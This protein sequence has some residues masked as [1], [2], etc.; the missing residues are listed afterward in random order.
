MSSQKSGN[1]KPNITMSEIARL[2][3]VSQSTVLRV[4]SGTTPVAP[5]KQAQVLE[6]IE[7][8]NFRPNL[9]AQGLVNGKTFQIGVLTRHL[10]SPFFSEMLRGMSRAMEGTNYHPVIGL[11]SDIPRED[12]NAL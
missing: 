10:G 6:V 7:R 3:G 1:R 12:R 4:L 11:G 8:L 5:D 9:A 2:A